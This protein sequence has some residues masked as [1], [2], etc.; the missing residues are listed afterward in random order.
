MR[1]RKYLG[2]I[3]FSAS[4]TKKKNAHWNAKTE[5][6]LFTDQNLLRLLR[7]QKQ[8]ICHKKNLDKTGP[9]LEFVALDVP[10]S[11]D[12]IFKKVYLDGAVQ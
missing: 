5:I 1:F 8:L 10:F 3:R 2:Q 11:L 4:P 9:T 6:Y 12:K 7:L